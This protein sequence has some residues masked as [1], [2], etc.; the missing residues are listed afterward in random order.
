MS[1][2]KEPVQQP[3]KSPKKHRYSAFTPVRKGG[4]APV[5]P[6]SGWLFAYSP[7]RNRL[8]PPKEP[9][10]LR[11][12]FSFPGSRPEAGK[13]HRQRVSGEQAGSSEAAE[14]KEAE[15][16]AEVLRP[17]RSFPPPGGS[18][19]APGSRSCTARSAKHP[20]DGTRPRPG[21]H[22]LRFPPPVRRDRKQNSPER[23]TKKRK[24]GIQIYFVVTLL[25]KPDDGVL[26]HVQINGI[27]FFPSSGSSGRWSV[28]ELEALNFAASSAPGPG[29]TELL[30]HTAANVPFQQSIT[31]AGLNVSRTCWRNWRRRRAAATPPPPP[32]P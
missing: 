15:Q 26:E 20:A 30:H 23:R 27:N 31:S 24:R 25:R 12:Q 28:M 7:C 2:V 32:P 3:R 18:S 5:L 11:V 22:P 19:P 8:K 14:R 1:L 29:G 6:G 4:F 10:I 9:G 17:P 21:A 13:P 16:E